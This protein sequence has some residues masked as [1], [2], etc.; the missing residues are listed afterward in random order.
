MS[1]YT[2]SDDVMAGIKAVA[3]AERALK[4]SREA[5]RAAVASD[6]LNNPDATNKQVADV[7]PFTEEY[8]RQ[9]AREFDVPR[10]RQP[11]VRSIKGA[12][13]TTK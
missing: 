9:V 7:L 1:Q 3:D 13:R 12:K 5:L 10:K 4:R 8:V 2:P 11:T 6:L